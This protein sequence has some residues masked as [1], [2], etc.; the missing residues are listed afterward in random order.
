MILFN[1]AATNDNDGF[2]NL[3]TLF[4]GEL[5]TLEGVVDQTGTRAESDEDSV[6]GISGHGG[7]GGFKRAPERRSSGNAGFESGGSETGDNFRDTVAD[8][9]LIGEVLHVVAVGVL[10]GLHDGEASKSLR[11]SE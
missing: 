1:V 2:T 9:E 10:A 6:G 3:F 8:F 11:E 5:T 7:G 4:L